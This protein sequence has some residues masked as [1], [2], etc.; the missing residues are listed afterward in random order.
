MAIASGVIDTAELTRLLEENGDVPVGDTPNCPWH[1]DYARKVYL[2]A[3]IRHCKG[4]LRKI[5]QHW[6]CDSERTLRGQIKK[7][8]LWDVLEQARASRKQ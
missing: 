3:L 8:G 4:N 6:D 1:I 2:Q 7:L 5:A